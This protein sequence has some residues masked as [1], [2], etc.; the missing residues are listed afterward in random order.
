MSVLSSERPHDQG[1]EHSMAN[2][3]WNDAPAF[4]AAH[5][6]DD[7]SN[8]RQCQVD[9]AASVSD[10]KY[11]R[12][13]EHDENLISSFPSQVSPYKEKAA[14]R[15]AAKKQL[16]CYRRD[17]YRPH[18]SPCGHTSV[19]GQAPVL[20]IDPE[21]REE[22]DRRERRPLN[23]PTV[24]TLQRQDRSLVRAAHLPSESPKRNC[25]QTYDPPIGNSHTHHCE[26]PSRQPSNWQPLP[27]PFHSERLRNDYI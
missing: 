13:E 6:V 25:K 10:P 9:P 11:G 27:P 12:H 8:D 5:T 26:S 22:A 24:Y 14:I 18:Y 1:V 4:P 17:E 2:D 3:R 16:F 15:Q 21:Q 19:N 7:A 20:H 23:G